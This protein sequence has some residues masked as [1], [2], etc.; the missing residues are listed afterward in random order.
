MP[1]MSP[2]RKGMRQPQD[3]NAAVDM[4]AAKTAP[5]AEPSRMPAALESRSEE[6]TSEL[7][8]LRHLDSPEPITLSLHDALPIYRRTFA[9]L[10]RRRL[11][12]MPAEKVA[13]DAHNEP[14]QEG[15]APT[16]GFQR[17]GRHAGRKNR[18]NC[19]AEQD[20]RGV[21]IQIGRAHV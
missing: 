21:G 17:R 9:P 16:P 13:S 3:S 1:T 18:T 2:S 10:Y 5:T 8:S 7:Q 11:K 6:H 15:N 20:A 19:G 4:L 14:E 12:H